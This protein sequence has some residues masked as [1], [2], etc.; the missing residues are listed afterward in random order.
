MTSIE[1][2]QIIIWLFFNKEMCMRARKLA[3]PF[4]CVKPGNQQIICQGLCNL[5]Q[6]GFNACFIVRHIKR[7][8]YLL[9]ICD[10]CPETEMSIRKSK[11]L[12][13]IP[14]VVE[15]LYVEITNYN[16]LR[17]EKRWQ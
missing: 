8:S 9:K 7:S 13:R 11:S 4:L 16:T 2:V 12:Q 17:D 5:A 10:H 14:M 6:K 3:F 15:F 1:Q